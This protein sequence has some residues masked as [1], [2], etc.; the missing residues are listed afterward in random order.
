MGWEFAISS[1]LD[2]FNLPLNISLSYSLGLTNIIPKPG[3][4]EYFKNR[5]VNITVA[6]L[7]KIKE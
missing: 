5:S 7:F 1:G 3:K 2:K 6:Y 4:D